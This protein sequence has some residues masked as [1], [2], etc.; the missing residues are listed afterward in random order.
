MDP[1]SILDQGNMGMQKH[2]ITKF[3]GPLALLIVLNNVVGPRSL[4]IDIRPNPQ[5][6]TIEI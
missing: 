6:Q 3:I 5:N 1:K 2:L 4:G